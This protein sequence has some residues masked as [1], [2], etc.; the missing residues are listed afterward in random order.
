M[1]RNLKIFIGLVIAATAVD[2]AANNAAS[3]LHGGA[4]TVASLVLLILSLWVVFDLIV[5]VIYRLVGVTEKLMDPAPPRLSH[6]QSAQV[7]K[8]WM[9]WLVSSAPVILIYTLIFD[10]THWK[11]N[12]VAAGV[13][14]VVVLLGVTNSRQKIAGHTKNEIFK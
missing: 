3:H 4:Q 9:V 14:I 8:Y 1:T 13:V 2:L 11:S 10:H 7:S 5:K 6:Q 12:L